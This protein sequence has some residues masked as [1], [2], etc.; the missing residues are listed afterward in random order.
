V[1]AIAQRI[2][3]GFLE[4]QWSKTASD[5]GTS[6]AGDKE[7]VYI[8]SQVVQTGKCHRAFDDK[9]KAKLVEATLARY[10]IGVVNLETGAWGWVYE[11][12]TLFQ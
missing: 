2:V 8:A 7:A 6:F 10:N 11:G 5:L 3:T 4:D 1:S 9:H 12:S